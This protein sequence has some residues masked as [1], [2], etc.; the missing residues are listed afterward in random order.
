[1]AGRLRFADFELDLAAYALRGPA[2][3]IKLE[4]MPMEILI[5]LAQ[6]PGE[7]VT[8]REIRSL[9]WSDG[10][11]VEYDS[12]INTVMRKIRRVLGDH[13]ERPRFIE[14][15]VGKG[16][17]FVAPV[18]GLVSAATNERHATTR[19]VLPAAYE[20]YVRGRHAW[21]KRT[22]PDLRAAIRLFQESIDA[23]PAYAPAFAGLADAYAQL[24]YG[25]YVA[26]E[27]SF[28]RAR[29]A[30]MRAVELDPTLPEAHA[31]LAFALM[32]YDWD[33]AAA[34]LEFKQALTLHPGSALAHQWFAYLLTAMERPVV[35][36]EREIES[37]KRLDPLS[38]A[39]LID[40]AYILHYYRR[41]S[42]A[43]RSVRLALDMNPAFPLGYFW[44][45]R[46]CTAEARYEE[47]EA[48][49]QNIGPLRTWTPAMAVRGYLY[50]KTG[51][52]DE[53]LGVLAAFDTLAAGGG[54]ASGYAV[55][56]VHA[57]I[58]DRAAALSALERAVRERSHWLVWLKRDPRWD[59]IRSDP[60]FRAL[61]TQ[62]GLPS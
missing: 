57:G 49:L 19:P 17:R 6:R 9:L 18:E 55:A 7:L 4:R 15:V 21:N 11:N 35:E 59:D 29:A 58:G 33:F 32:Y 40:H 42:E 16:Y 46:I 10:V 38:V 14:T 39:I 26:P 28:L 34:E 53:A 50:G 44:L 31:A 22:E 36:A 12:A 20:A 5:L 25:S 62:V 8:R 2:G 56:V 54:Y 47:A 43:L 45:A 37:A 30:A 24:G 41:N 60:R 52:I 1:M 23:D 61:V 51:R 3:P 27:E 13:P 48:A